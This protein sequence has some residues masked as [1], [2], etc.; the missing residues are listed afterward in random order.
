[1]SDLIAEQGSTEDK[2][3]HTPYN[4]YLV[5]KDAKDNFQAEW[6][7]IEEKFPITSDMDEDEINSAEQSRDSTFY[8]WYAPLLRNENPQEF[9]LLPSWNDYGNS[10]SI[11]PKQV[12]DNNEFITDIA[13]ITIKSADQINSIMS[14]PRTFQPS[15]FQKLIIDAYTNDELERHG[16]YNMSMAGSIWN[17]YNGPGDL[18]L[19]S[20]DPGLLDQLVGFTASMTNPI[21]FSIS[22]VTAGGGSSLGKNI[23]KKI[24]PKYSYRTRAAWGWTR[25]KTESFKNYWRAK[26]KWKMKGPWMDHHDEFL[27][28]AQARFTNTLANFGSGFGFMFPRYFLNDLV[29]Q[30]FEDPTKEFNYYDAMMTSL[31]GS[32][33]EGLKFAAVGDIGFKSPLWTIKNTPNSRLLTNVTSKPGFQKS[34]EA[35][36]NSKVFTASRQA[37]TWS[38]FNNLQ[39]YIEDPDTYDK[40]VEEAGGHTPYLL[41]TL[42][43]DSFIYGT[44][45]FQRAAWNRLT[46]LFKRMNFNQKNSTKKK[47]TVNE[48]ALVI[49]ENNIS[50]VTNIKGDVTVDFPVEFRKEFKNKIL[51]GEEYL[52]FL[53]KDNFSLKNLKN[54]YDIEFLETVAE[55]Q[56]SGAGQDIS[57]IITYYIKNR[58][59]LFEEMGVE[60][61]FPDDKSKPSQTIVVDDAKF[62]EFIESGLKETLKDVKPELIKDRKLTLE[63]FESEQKLLLDEVNTLNAEVTKFEENLSV[64]YPTGE[65]IPPE[66]SLKFKEIKKE[67]NS[68][69]ER[70]EELKNAIDEYDKTGV[71][72]L[73]KSITKISKKS[74][75]AEKTTVI[76]ALNAFENFAN[77]AEEIAVHNTVPESMIETTDT[78]IALR[79]KA[80]AIVNRLLDQDAYPIGKRI[81]KQLTDLEKE[82]ADK[83]ITASEF[84]TRA[85]VI[86]GEITGTKETDPDD[87]WVER[88]EKGEIYFSTPDKTKE[89]VEMLYSHIKTGESVPSLIKSGKINEALK[90]VATFLKNHGPGSKLPVEGQNEYG[91]NLNLDM[92]SRAIHEH[93]SAENVEVFVKMLNSTKHKDIRRV[94]EK[95]IINF[96]KTQA[97]MTGLK[98][99]KSLTK[100]LLDLKSRAP[101]NSSFL[102][103]EKGFDINSQDL[104]TAYTDLGKEAREAQQEVTEQ[105]V[106]LKT[107]GGEDLVES[108]GRVNKEIPY[109]P[110]VLLQI[111][112]TAPKSIQNKQKKELIWKQVDNLKSRLIGG[113]ESIGIRPEE[114]NR[115]TPKHV[116]QDGEVYSIKLSKSAIDERPSIVKVGRGATVDRN[117]VISKKLYNDLQSFIKEHGIQENQQL[118]SKYS[119]TFPTK[120]EIGKGSDYK[121]LW[122]NL[123]DLFIGN[124]KITKIGG[125]SLESYG[126]KWLRSHVA[127]KLKG[128]QD[129]VAQVEMIGG[130][131]SVTYLAPAELGVPMSNAYK[132]LYQ[133]INYTLGHDISFKGLKETNYG[134]NSLKSIMENPHLMGK[135][136]NSLRNYLSIKDPTRADLDNILKDIWD[137]ANPG[138]P[139]SSL[140]KVKT[141]FKE[142]KPVHL[143]ISIDPGVLGMGAFGVPRFRV[144]GAKEAIDRVFNRV[145]SL[146]GGKIRDKI[147]ADDIRTNFDDWVLA[148]SEIIGN[149]KGNDVYGKFKDELIKK[150]PRL[151]RKPFDDVLKEVFIEASKRLKDKMSYDKAIRNDLRKKFFTLSNRMFGKGAISDIQKQQLI[152]EIATHAA[153]SNPMAFGKEGLSE[154]A[155]SKRPIREIIEFKASLNNFIKLSKTGVKELKH[156]KILLAESMRDQLGLSESDWHNILEQH[157]IPGLNLFLVKAYK[158]ND[159][160]GQLESMREDQ[161]INPIPDALNKD[162]S[163][164]G[165]TQKADITFIRNFKSAFY[166]FQLATDVIAKLGAPHLADLLDKHQSK[167]GVYQAQLG[168]LEQDM[169]L[170]L[171]S[172]MVV[173][174]VNKGIYEFVPGVRLAGKT[175]WNKYKDA[176]NDIKDVELVKELMTYKSKLQPD[177]LLI[178]VLFPK[179]VIKGRVIDSHADKIKYLVKQSYDKDWNVR[180]DTVEGHAMQVF[181]DWYGQWPEHLGQVL[182]GTLPTKEYLKSVGLYGKNGT[183]WVEGYGHRRLSIDFVRALNSQSQGSLPPSV[184]EGLKFRFAQD[185]LVEKGVKI[186]R[187]TKELKNLAQNTPIKV[188]GQSTTVWQE[189]VRQQENQ[190]EQYF[191]QMERNR[192]T[193]GAYVLCVR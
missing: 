40:A 91:R 107:S 99:D 175:R 116:A 178:D 135:I 152:T 120:K 122:D 168:I 166:R 77:G 79:E 82:F 100:T 94:S 9:R 153:I 39:R 20:Y 17:L 68:K 85:E 129:Q 193:A 180:I 6:N 134:S 138:N 26:A 66:L 38:G 19:S 110:N 187:T 119:R 27:D 171:S 14:A 123:G 4:K 53:E 176:F 144:T 60:I 108:V 34:V 88:T 13:P 151:K 67:V 5:L 162:F 21:D 148:G 29:Q 16:M 130:E 81:K 50:K 155:L 147:I 49:A 47:N 52:E 86:K 35:A 7:L 74:I 76:K 109:V 103:I 70:I 1:M 97:Q 185:M 189:A 145:D 11:T 115:I 44:M 160:I 184:V 22:F 142:Q 59:R 73:T 10:N 36:K 188:D 158:I 127:N 92:L 182:L 149:L 54:P 28:L 18:D 191:S 8:E 24:G 72:P 71:L 131:R 63:E 37:M 95:D 113:I 146:F 75:E 57:D 41:N 167:L 48:E 121:S 15:Y 30:K 181:N 65:D 2:N 3:Y 51:E 111:D 98:G 105:K 69:L 61:K 104:K 190:G 156:E 42:F 23:A 161:F 128:I 174:D 45:R 31:E 46:P 84:L 117:V 164:L 43:A 163:K 12:D 183:K 154:D 78:D 112:K 83:K 141:W 106:K 89:T 118:F 58:T 132:L 159:I 179:R 64:N 90:D 124:K 96:A 87:I 139:I 140:P 62:T 157:S 192:I 169:A 55:M 137:V 25:T 80:T 56:A 177:K 93:G 32:F 173:T 170:A 101:K 172:K 102:P 114:V 186:P 33:I 126:A 125:Q 150:Q 165:I 133:F 143:K 136:Q